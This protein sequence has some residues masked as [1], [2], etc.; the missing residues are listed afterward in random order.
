MHFNVY[1]LYYSQFPHQYV[2]ACTATISKEILL[3]EY[4][5]TNMVSCVAGTPK[6]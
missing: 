2:S 6:Q 1:D 5:G 4:K 3:Q